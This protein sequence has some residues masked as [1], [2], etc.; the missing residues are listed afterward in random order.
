MRRFY[1]LK[2]QTHLYTPSLVYAARNRPGRLFSKRSNELLVRALHRKPLVRLGLHPR[3]ANHP[4]LIRHVQ[5]LVERL[6]PGR[7]AMTKSAF[8]ADVIRR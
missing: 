6:L 4:D 1:L 2:Q 3:D 5:Q 8:A 7:T